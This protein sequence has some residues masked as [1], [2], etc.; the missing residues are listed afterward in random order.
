LGQSQ[1]F[2]VWKEF[3]RLDCVKEDKLQAFDGLTD[4]VLRI[5]YESNIEPTVESIVKN[6]MPGHVKTDA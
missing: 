4:D 2:A 5:L 3:L 1:P 6:G